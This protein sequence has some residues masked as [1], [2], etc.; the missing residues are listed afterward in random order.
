RMGE[1]ELPLQERFL[2]WL[3]SRR[4]V[5]VTGPKSAGPERVPTIS[6]RSRRKSPA[7]ILPAVDRSGVAIRHGHMY[8][9]RLCR[10]LG[11]D[12]DEGVI[13]V[14]FVHYNT[15]AEVDRLIG[16]LEEALA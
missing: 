12:T 4:D 8:S 6:F 15:P 14:S 2:G 11:I 3:I 16:V 10:A 13:R 1:M 5:I 7:A 9:Y